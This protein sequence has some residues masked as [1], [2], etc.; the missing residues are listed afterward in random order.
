MREQNT[1]NQFI[2]QDRLDGVRESLDEKVNALRQELDGKADARRIE[3]EEKIEK[4]VS[5]STFKTVVTITIGVI[6]ALFLLI[7]GT[8][9]WILTLSQGMA[10]LE[11][12]VESLQPTSIQQ[13]FLQNSPQNAV[14]K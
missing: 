10:R 7:I 11:A 14:R 13:P 12:K 8:Y 2:W 1:N 3:L 9:V 5:D 6:G 4:R